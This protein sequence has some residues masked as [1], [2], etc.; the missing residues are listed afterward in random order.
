MSL[1]FNP[2]NTNFISTLQDEADVE[3]FVFQA[4]NELQ[5][6]TINNV[7]KM[8]VHCWGGGGGG[9]SSHNGTGAG[10]GGSFTIL[11]FPYYPVV[12]E[13]YVEAQV[14]FGGTGGHYIPTL[15]NEVITGATY[16]PAS[17]GQLTQLTFKTGDGRIL[18]EFVSY[19]GYGGGGNVGMTGFAD[20]G[21]GGFNSLVLNSSYA[22]MDAYYIRGPVNS[23]PGGGNQIKPS[24]DHCQINYMN[25]T[26][27]GGGASRNL[28]SNNDGGSF[29]L[30]EGGKGSSSDLYPIF[31]GGGGS[32][33]YGKGGDGFDPNP[34]TYSN[35]NFKFTITQ[36]GSAN[37]SIFKNEGL[38]TRF[39]TLVVTSS[40]SVI[41]PALSP[42]NLYSISATTPSTNNF[43]YVIR[44]QFKNPIDLVL[45]QTYDFYVRLNVYVPTI[46]YFNGQSGETNSGAG[47][48]G[49]PLGQRIGN[50]VV[51]YLTDTH[52]KISSA[53]IEHKRFAVATHYA[54]HIY[55]P[56]ISPNMLTISPAVF[57]SEQNAYICVLADPTGASLPTPSNNSVFNLTLFSGSGNYQKRGG[58]G[59]DGL[60]IL[61]V[62]H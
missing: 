17:N 55:I 44:D 26:G 8:V 60:V 62:Y 43:N 52:F 46:E 37:L 57:N 10:A 41:I 3:Q 34:L 7:N 53:P 29:L 35:P 51:T 24:G 30:H 18:K 32:T 11:D 36:R 23:L 45:N 6:I 54:T 40:A 38:N 21:P 13:V 14:G 19:G 31:G 12:E 5:K 59:G 33:Y 56:G 22:L 2:S 25:V 4:S 47:G 15:T 20:G 1:Q 48:G 28:G 50:F 42:D 39:H 16:V 61:E 27:S 58:K 9:G 49:A